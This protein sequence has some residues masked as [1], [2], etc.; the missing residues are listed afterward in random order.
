MFQIKRYVPGDKVES[1]RFAWLPTKVRCHSTQDGYWIWLKKYFHYKE[2]IRGNITNYW[3]DR[4][5]INYDKDR[6]QKLL[7][8]KGIR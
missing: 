3:I 5:Y 8:E 2:M 4:K 1:Y 7:K 6:F